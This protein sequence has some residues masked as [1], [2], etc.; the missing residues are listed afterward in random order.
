MSKVSFISFGASR[1]SK[2]YNFFK[3]DHYGKFE[4]LTF[5]KF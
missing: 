3:G 2:E 5:S 1:I 4:F